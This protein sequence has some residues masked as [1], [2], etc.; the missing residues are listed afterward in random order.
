MSRT[1]AICMMAVAL[2]GCA[3]R[4][5]AS[6]PAGI[7]TV[8]VPVLKN[9]T[10]AHGLDAEVTSALVAEFQTEGALRPVAAG[11]A[12]CTLSGSVVSYR[13]DVVG[14]GAMKVPTVRQ[15]VIEVNIGVESVADGNKL[16]EGLRVTSVETD[17]TAGCFRID[18]GESE[19]LGRQRAV[20]ALARNVVRSVVERW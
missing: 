17:P 16:V 9:E 2:G 18:A 7:R 10:R 12:D 19:R 20:R 5:G 11:A 3:Y 15:V 6:L 4:A 14:K 13:R 1:A 8:S